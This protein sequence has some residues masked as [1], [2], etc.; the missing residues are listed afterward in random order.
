MIKEHCFQKPWI[1][2]FKRHA[3]YNKINPPLVEKMIRALSLLQHLKVQ[4]LH[5]V[6][7]GGT[8]LILLLK[9]ARRF[10]VDIDILTEAS[11]ECPKPITS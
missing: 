11:R 4:G 9:H 7:K 6:F 3:A 2:S 10:S 5:F 8:S 1:D